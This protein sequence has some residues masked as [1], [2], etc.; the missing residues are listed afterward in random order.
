MID[1]IGRSVTY[2]R[3]AVTERCN[4]HCRYCTPG[5]GEC[6]EMTPGEILKIVRAAAALG[7]VKIRLTGGE[8]T[9]RRD[10]VDLV[11]EVR[12][13]PG[14]EQ[15]ALTTNGL[16][17]DRLAAPLA[18]AG[19]DRLNLSIDTLRADRFRQLTRGGELGRALAG[20]DAARAAGLGPIK[21]N[22]VVMRDVNEDEVGDFAAFA[23][24]HSLE[25]R[26]IEYMPTDA[27]SVGRWHMPTSALQE[28][29]LANY[30]ANPLPQERNGG[31]ATVY[32]LD[33]QGARVGFIHAVSNPFCDRCNRLRITASGKVRSCL[34][35]GGDVDLLAAL[36]SGGDSEDLQALLVEA[37]A[38]KPA[39]YE[40]HARDSLDMRRV[41][42]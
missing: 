14:I 25:V 26:F 34:L 11:R 4:L 8:P 19:I 9:L 21:V 36:R 37:A 33:E 1:P 7:I 16:L 28:Q 41:G 22:C 42:G 29:L 18:A 12:A 32:A 40:L 6:D 39:T 2:L 20:L 35:S 10:L 27:T 13:V 31:P 15:L 30:D 3:L 17:L 5:G 23:L 24:E 38:L